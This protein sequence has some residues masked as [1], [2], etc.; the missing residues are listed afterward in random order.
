M[1]PH[2]LLFLLSVC[3]GCCCHGIR[4]FLIHSS[5]IQALTGSHIFTSS[6]TMPVTWTF[7]RDPSICTSENQP[8]SP[9][10][11]VSKPRRISCRCSRFFPGVGRLAALQDL[12][13]ILVIVPIEAP[14]PFPRDNKLSLIAQK[15]SLCRRGPIINL[16]IYPWQMPSIVVPVPRV[17]AV[18]QVTRDA[19]KP[20]AQHSCFRHKILQQPPLE[21][22]KV[23]DLGLDEESVLGKVVPVLDDVREICSALAATVREMDDAVGAQVVE[24]RV[25]GGVCVFSVHDD[26]GVQRRNVGEE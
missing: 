26:V 7:S 5:R 3:M 17:R 23:V 6:F 11:S 19:P 12:A 4:P 24:D 21:V 2:A 10:K 14:Y 22:A 8:P 13:E 25:G 9:F 15:Q 20:Q 1:A 16:L 18:S